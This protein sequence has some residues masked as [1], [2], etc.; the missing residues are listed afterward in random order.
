LADKLLTYTIM[1][2]GVLQHGAQEKANR[3]NK[4]NNIT[5]PATARPALNLD[6]ESS[7]CIII[8]KSIFLRGMHFS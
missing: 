8:V 7:T 2:A 6:K 5:V 3:E 4:R 1:A